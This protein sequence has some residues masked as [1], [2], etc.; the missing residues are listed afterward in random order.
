MFKI[1]EQS[2]EFQLGSAQTQEHKHSNKAAPVAESWNLSQKL[3]MQV[4]VRNNYTKYIHQR[5]LLTPGPFIQPQNNYQSV[6]LA[7]RQ[8]KA[9]KE[10][11]LSCRES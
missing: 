10:A 1:Q 7:N 11:Q 5:F 6:S 2:K 9:S 3:C 8:A 4:T